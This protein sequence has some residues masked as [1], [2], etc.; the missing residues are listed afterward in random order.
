MGGMDTADVLRAL[1]TRID[2]RDWPGLAE[3]LHPDL[4]VRLVHTGEVLDRE[5]WV[6]LNAEYPVVVRFEIEDLVV[7]GSRG[8]ARSRT[9]NDDVTYYV[10]SFATVEDGL[11]RDLVEVWTDDVAPPPAHRPAPTASPA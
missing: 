7:D 6:R 10:A 4:R 2:A 8:V 3:L 11:V 1:A 9:W 5:S